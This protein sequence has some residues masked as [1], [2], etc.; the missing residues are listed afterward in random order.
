MNE[1][2]EKLIEYV[3]NIASR[4]RKLEM[5]IEKN[6]WPDESR[7][8]KL[9]SLWEYHQSVQQRLNS[10]TFWDEVNKNA[11]EKLSK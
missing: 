7:K 5:E 9:D 8:N 10:T 1:A 3:S 2:I 6:R 4:V 11:T